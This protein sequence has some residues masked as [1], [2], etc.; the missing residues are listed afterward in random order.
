MPHRPSKKVRR[1][2]IPPPDTKQ[3]RTSPDA[4]AW[5][6][7]LFKWKVNDNYIDMGH[8]EWGWGD[9]PIS[10]FFDVLKESLQK[11]EDMPWNDVLH[12]ASC[13]PMP[14]HKIAKRARERFIAICPDVDTL[15]QVDFSKLGRVWGVKAGQYL[16]L[17]WY[18]PNHTVYPIN[19]R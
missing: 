1:D 8:E 9:V 17:V 4:G 7:Q 15:H 13:H 18:D 12:R 6:Q 10:D 11:Y 3:P 19:R 14:I 16:H 5:A 2:K